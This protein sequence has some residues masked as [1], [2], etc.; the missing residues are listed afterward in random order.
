M[1]F[2]RKS[3]ARHLVALGALLPAL[4]LLSPAASA[5]A[6][7]DRIKQA[8]TVKLG[9]GA[10][11]PLAGKDASGNP[12]GFAADL[13]AKVAEGLKA[14]L[15]APALKVEYVPVTREEGVRAVADGKVDVLCAPT[16]PTTTSRKQVS[17]SIPIFASGVG[18]MVRKDTSDRLKAIL[19]GYPEERSPTW[20]A[21]ADKLLRNSTIVVVK[22]SRAE[23]VVANSLNKL[24]L[25]PRV[26][27]VDDYAAGV[28]SVR[29]GRANVFFGD[30]LLLLDAVK[31]GGGAPGELQVLYRHFTYEAFAFAVTRGDEELRL[32]VDSALSKAFRSAEFPALYTKWL[33]SAPTETALAMLRANTLPE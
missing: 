14:D 33:G 26:H 21:N 16:V 20:R 29:E 2:L 1:N 24:Q 11:N 18:A 3:R 28:A 30:R 27:H 15:G 9:Y 5:G 13:C 19:S 6:A 8:G 7:A 12:V 23:D 4:A 32:S 22:G 17:Y 31:R 10:D 25:V